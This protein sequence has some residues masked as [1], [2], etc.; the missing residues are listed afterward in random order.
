MRILFRR[1]AYRM[2]GSI[3]D[4]EDVAQETMLRVVEMGSSLESIESHF[5]WLH[6]AATEEAMRIL[7]KRSPVP[8]DEIDFPDLGMDRWSG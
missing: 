8:I 1:H 7:E 6:I 5:E 4:A 2:T 3:L